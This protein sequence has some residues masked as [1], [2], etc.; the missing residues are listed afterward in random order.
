MNQDLHLLCSCRAGSHATVLSL[1][2]VKQFTALTTLLQ[3]LHEAPK[4]VPCD[5]EV[6][7]IICS[8]HLVVVGC[9]DAGPAC[10]RM[11]DVN[12]ICD[13]IVIVGHPHAAA[14]TEPLNKK[15]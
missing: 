14:H 7:P 2:L 13:A 15:T 1:A 11:I 12:C 9:Q 3:G 4:A 10:S 5:L 8:N 6:R